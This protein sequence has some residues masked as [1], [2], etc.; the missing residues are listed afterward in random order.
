MLKVL[1]MGTPDF[2]AECLKAIVENGWNVVGA[3]TQP[4][5]PSGRGY[6]LIPCA[7]KKLSLVHISEP[8]RP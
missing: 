1:F 6:R 3:V 7:V 5:R 8:T 4:D 2:A